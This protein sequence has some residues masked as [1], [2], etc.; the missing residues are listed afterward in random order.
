MLTD[1]PVM[2]VDGLMVKSSGKS[3]A[4]LAS[5]MKPLLPQ[6]PQLKDAKT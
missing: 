3:V 1:K 5:S 6:D 2:V 4:S